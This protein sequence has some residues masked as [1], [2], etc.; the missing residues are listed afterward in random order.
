MVKSIELD[1]IV[2][3]LKNTSS[4][5]NIVSDRVFFWEPMYEQDWQ[6]IVLNSVSQIV[7]R[8]S[9][10]ALIEVRIIWN[11]ENVLK[12]DLVKTANT[13]T[14]VLVSENPKTFWT[15]QYY[16]CVEWG[17]FRIFVDDKNRNILIKDFIFYFLS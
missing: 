3:G 14:D 8:V 16:K 17:G 9:K 15:F 10:Q 5:S 2:D 12:R 6:Y 7:D 4:I 11:D 1:Q 13:I